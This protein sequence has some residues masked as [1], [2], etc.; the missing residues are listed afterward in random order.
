MSRLSAEMLK[1][2][3]AEDEPS[4]SGAS[5]PGMLGAGATHRGVPRWPHARIFR[6]SPSRLGIFALSIFLP[7]LLTWR[8]ISLPSSAG[9]RK[10]RYWWRRSRRARPRT[11]RRVRIE[12][13]VAADLRHAE[14]AE[15][16]GALVG[17]IVRASSSEHCGG[18]RASSGVGFCRWCARE[19]E[20]D[21]SPVRACAS[22]VGLS[23][24]R[25]WSAQWPG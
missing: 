10:T 15:P 9:S 11:R 25:A 17:P 19:S 1:V 13:D 24:Q 2:E 8:S 3:Q 6:C 21:G 4:R 7:S 22:D 12:H 16:H 18:Q 23:R 20:C 5:F 14:V